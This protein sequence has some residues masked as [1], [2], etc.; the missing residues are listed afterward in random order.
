MLYASSKYTIIKELP[1]GKGYADIALIPYIPDIP[2]IIIELKNDK[3][4]ETAINQI[5]DRHYDEVL[6]HYRGNMLFVGIN[7]S[8][9]TKKHQCKIEKILYN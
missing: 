2:A 3:T 4:A 1:T 8:P 7:Y 9:D 5:K 6:Q